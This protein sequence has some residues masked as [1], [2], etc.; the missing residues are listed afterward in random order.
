ML[1]AEAPSDGKAR[2]ALGRAS[3]EAGLLEMALLPDQRAVTTCDGAPEVPGYEVISRIGSGSSGEVWLADELETDRIVALKILHRHGGSG[4]SEEIMQREIRML[5][6]LVHPNLVLLHRAI[7]TADGR[8]GLAMEW[9]DGWPLDEWLERH[10]DLSLDRKLQLFHG[11]VR[12]VAYLHD[13]GIIHR[14]LK[15]AN[16]IVD[17]AAVAKIVDFGLARLHREGAG[18]NG[19]S[20]GVSGT[21]HFMA[22]EQAANADGARAMPVDVYALGLIFHR[23]LTG[24]WLLCGGGTHTETLALVLNPPPLALHGPA[25]SLPRDLQSILRQ[26]LNP[27]PALRYR[28]ARDLEAD[29]D[30]F[31]AK[32]PVSARKHTFFYLTATLLR[33]QARRSI[34][35]GC[36]VLAG[37]AAGGVIYHRHRKVADQNEANLRYAYTLTSFTLGQLRDELRV[38]APA[39]ESQPQAVGG[40][41]PGSGDGVAPML[42]VDAEGKLDL[43]YYQ[44]LLADTRS[45]ASESHARYEA[46]L[47]SIQPALDLYSQL[48]RE[49][50]D[51]PKRLLDAARARLSFARMLERT[52][53]TAA[54]GSEARKTLRQ[55]DRLADCPGFDP[56]PLPPLRCD[57]LRLLAEDAHHAG[58][59]VLACDFAREM[60][61]T[62]EA[63]PSGLLVRPEN[64]AAPRLAL[65]VSDLATYAI[66][67]DP[68]QVSEARREIDR[69]TVVCRTA[70]ERDPRSPALTRGLAYCLHAQARLLL[71]QGQGESL[72]RLFEEGDALLIGE[73]SIVRLSSFPLVRAFSITATAWAGTLLDHPDAEMAK[74]SL[75]VA[76]RLTTFLQANGAGSEEMMIQRARL[77]LYESRLA[78]R[79]G[80][81]GEGAR[82]VARAVRILRPRQLREPDRLTLALLT[83]AALRQARGL[84]DFPDAEWNEAHHGPHLDRLFQQLSARSDELTPEQRRELSSLLEP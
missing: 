54:A 58:N 34:L 30:R 32:Q 83:A 55:L 18:T 46:A 52:G 22:P 10:P 40:D 36:L 44:A 64:E 33:R 41:L 1:A 81:L 17:A 68:A 51:D 66:A 16:L 14:D 20:I 23:L 12:G 13:Q 31:T 67:A 71:H 43:R 25:G 59:P 7:A 15:P 4:T 50:P 28:H 47:K 57:V 6:E 11:I 5:A 19:G 56:A 65:A 48:A 80:R 29:L 21:L 74:A 2:P 38:V 82:A 62:A 53:H 73:G 3:P 26:A 35:A 60:L 39:E 27:D 37:V 84:A 78:G 77:F 72:R 9:I 61:I 63:L 24:E 75:T 79:S 8:Q 49:A 42:P 69:A 70:H 45:A 76:R